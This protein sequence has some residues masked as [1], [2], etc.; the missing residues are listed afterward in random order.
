MDTV[1][2][3]HKSYYETK[4][5][6]YPTDFDDPVPIQF[7]SVKPGVS[8]LFALEIPGASA[9]WIR[10]AEKMLEYTLR[11]VGLGGKTSAGYGWFAETSALIRPTE[12]VFLA[13]PIPD[14]SVIKGPSD[15][16]SIESMLK[17]ISSQETRN[18]IAQEL[19]QKI[20]AMGRWTDKQK[21]KPWRKAIEEALL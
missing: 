18:M 3:H 4:G 19:K 5:K 8:F 2:V 17:S 6:D 13:P 12:E 21:D 10:F 9:E 1:T 15:F 14:L 7:V 20:F 11:N 16:G